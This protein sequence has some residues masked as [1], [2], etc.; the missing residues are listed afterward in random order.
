MKVLITGATGMVGK[1]VLF[2]CLDHPQIE[3][4][5]T[6]GRST[7][8]IIHPKLY[9]IKHEDFSEFESIKDQLRGI[10]AAYLC[11]GVS[12]A[13]LSEEEY[14]RFT[15]DYTLSLAKVLHGLNQEMTM[16]Y[17]S[18]EGTDSSEKV[19][20]MWARVKGRT[21]NALIELAFKQAYMFRPG[22][23]IPLRGIKSR[24]RLY[25][26]VYDYFLWLVKLYKWIAPN[27]VVNT[28][29]LGLAMINATL[30]G[31]DQTILKSRDILALSAK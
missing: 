30:F 11:M 6:I 2:E 21:E 14:T 9:Q 3:R 20:S 5:I 23:I 16:T 7:L 28:T 17:V 19:R 8:E 18:G 1:G 25:Q 24:T 29:Q 31:Y 22:A 26:F 12:V 4:V 13:G 15:F 27:A 10:D